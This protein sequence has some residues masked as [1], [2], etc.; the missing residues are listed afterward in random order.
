M[1]IKNRYRPFYKNFLNLRENVQDRHKILKFKKQKWRRFQQSARKQLKFFKRYR[2]KDQNQLFISRFAGRGNSFKQNFKNNL[3]KRKLFSFFYGVLNKKYLKRHIVKSVLKKQN[4]KISNYKT[5]TIRFFESRLDTILYR[6]KFSLSIR[7]ASQLILHGHV[8]VNGKPVKTK[9]YLV[10]NNDLIEIAY[11]VTS[12][13]LVKKSIDRSNF[14]PIPPKNLIINYN[15]FQILF[16]IDEQFGS[17]ASFNHYLDIN[18]VV[19]NV[20]KF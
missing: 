3:R 17:L 4:L 5:K 9:S 13:D 12:R 14:W 11:N 1:K 7:G 15:T 10:R 16:I 8:L 2:I 19:A 6:A 18:S 20:K